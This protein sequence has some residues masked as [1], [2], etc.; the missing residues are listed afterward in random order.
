MRKIFLLS[1]ALTFALPTA[2]SAAVTLTSVDG[3]ASYSGPFTFDFESP[4]P[5]YSGLRAA[6]SLSGVRAQP[7]GSTGRYATSGPTDGIGILNLSAFGD[8]DTISFLWGSIDKYNKLEL[9][10]SGGTVFKFFTGSDVIENPNGNQS[11]PKTNR[12]VTL[13]FTGA[14]R[15]LI[16]SLRFA[17]TSNAFETDNFR[18]SSAVP[19]P[20]TW[21][22]M[23]LG[24]GLIGG[25]MRSRRQHKSNVQLAF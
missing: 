12:L 6:G 11:L 21:L 17:S 20:G 1:A 25:A 10:N 14:D 9:L 16:H 2:A 3:S 22:M 7:Y 19:E 18:I 13:T 4:T 23:L 15:S 8:I 5:E 24:F